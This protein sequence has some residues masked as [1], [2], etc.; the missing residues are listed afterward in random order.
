MKI[1]F[2]PFQ[3]FFD[4]TDRPRSAPSFR[5]YISVGKRG[6]K[7]VTED[8]RKRVHLSLSLR[9]E[10]EQKSAKKVEFQVATLSNVCCVEGGG[11]VTFFNSATNK[12]TVS[13]IVKGPTFLSASQSISACLS[14][15]LPCQ[16]STRVRRMQA[17]ILTAVWTE[18]RVKDFKNVANF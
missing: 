13:C 5:V 4:P 15:C 7:R 3:I 9:M 8:L 14:R 18:N 11:K 2:P 1:F 16:F 12:F 10:S 17:S 6:G